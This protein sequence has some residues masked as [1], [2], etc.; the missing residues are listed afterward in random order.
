[1]DSS[2]LFLNKFEKPSP[3]IIEKTILI[4]LLV[5]IPPVLWVMFSSRIM[6]PPVDIPWENLAQYHQ[7]EPR[8]LELK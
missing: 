6:S 8:N 1:M 3:Q 7:P 4:W 5:V 2:I